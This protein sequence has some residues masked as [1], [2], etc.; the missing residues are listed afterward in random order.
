MR[1]IKHEVLKPS[2]LIL[3]SSYVLIK[4]GKLLFRLFLALALFGHSKN[5]RGR[6]LLFSAPTTS[7]FSMA[8]C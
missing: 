7:L 4:I 3:W 5:C 6:R 1:F 8:R 2:A